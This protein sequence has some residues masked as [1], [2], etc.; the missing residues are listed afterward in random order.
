MPG[1]WVIQSLKR[2]LF[3]WGFFFFFQIPSNSFNLQHLVLALDAGEY[4]ELCNEQRPSQ[5]TVSTLLQR[6]TE[7]QNILTGLNSDQDVTR[8]QLRFTMHSTSSGN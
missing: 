3:F 1:N 7:R 8:V 5:T 2:S 4:V 6:R